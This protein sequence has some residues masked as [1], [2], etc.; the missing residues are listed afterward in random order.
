[1]RQVGSEDELKC[2]LRETLDLTGLRAGDLEADESFRAEVKYVAGI[3]PKQVVYF[4][5]R[6]AGRHS[7]QHADGGGLKHQWCT[8]DQAL[9]RVVFQSMQNILTSAERYIED[10]REQL[11]GTRAARD[12]GWRPARPDAL[13]S[14]MGRLTLGGARPARDTR[15]A[16]AARARADNPRYK[17]RLCEK[18]EQDGECPYYHKC[19]F[20]HGRGELRV[21]E[22]QPPRADEARAPRF[23][24]NPLYKTRLCQRFGELGECPYGE[25]C[26]F[27]HGDG[28]LRAAPEPAP[29]PRT[30]RDMHAPRDMQAR[31]PAEYNSHTWRRGASD[32][33]HAPRMARNQSWAGGAGA[34][35]P[36]SESPVASDDASGDP[37]P[38]PA[39]ALA[40]P[41]AQKIPADSGRAPRGRSDGDKP[42]IR[43]VEVSGRDLREMGS[44]L[45]D[46]DAVRPHNRT[47]ELESRLAAELA[48]V[49]GGSRLTAHELFKEIT[50]VEFRNNLT[51]Q[52]LL[53][54]VVPALFGASPVRVGDAIARNAELL[55]KI[56]GRPADQPLLLNAWLRMLADAAW[57]RRASE[58]LSALYDASLLDEDEFAA[59]F[60]A[61]NHDGCAPEIAAM[62][63]FAHW[64]AT[65]EEE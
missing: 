30:P 60:A 2:A 39:A 50:H 18:F 10:M 57:Q 31:A 61:R 14:R 22:P 54:V 3:Q 45:A 63:P 9:E 43:V 19:V 28:E 7:L 5:A 58:V 11:L 16:D 49:V 41:V 51:K 35:R 65:A 47:A 15:E 38:Q 53:N 27:A 25:K 12:D 32:G 55:A 34:A 62:R 29:S 20:A 23:S 13:E 56:A 64:L 46:G 44:P 4:L 26:Q 17:T 24:A 37:Q 33:E 52:Q 8:L 40:T 42:W 6:L 36:A 48:C 1:G 59:W 21:R